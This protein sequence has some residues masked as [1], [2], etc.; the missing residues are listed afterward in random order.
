MT[1]ILYPVQNEVWKFKLVD[2]DKI[3]EGSTENEMYP[4]QGL[5]VAGEC[6]PPS[7]II[8]E[9][10]ITDFENQITVSIDEMGVDAVLEIYMEVMYP[11]STADHQTLMTYIKASYAPSYFE[12]FEIYLEDG[13]G[14]RRIFAVKNDDVGSFKARDTDIFT[15]TADFNP[16]Y[17]CRVGIII[18]KPKKAINTGFKFFMS[19]F[20]LSDLRNPSYCKPEDVIRFLGL[21]D[22][23]G[24]PL[25]LTQESSPSYEDVCNHI[26]EAE[27]FIDAQTRT[28]F[29][30]NRELNEMHDEKLAQSLPYG[31]LYGIYRSAGAPMMYG[32]QLFEGVP[33]SLF[34]Q[35]IRPIDYSLGDKVEV[36]RLGT[37]WET[38]PE[39]RLWWD[40]QKGIIYIK[41]YFHRSD[42]SVRVTYRW[43]QD[44]VPHDITKCC[45]IQA[46][47]QIVATDW[48]RA[49]FPI[50]PEFSDMKAETL[51]SWTWEIKD[52]IK[53]Y[54]TQ[55]SVGCL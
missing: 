41:D 21:L 35:N 24:R 19:E 52:I 42:S 14:D 23:R 48:Y 2:G 10:G 6:V 26:I 27:A 16:A 25:I 38:L 44:K 15:D 34:R 31:G 36:R 28:S 9:E 18:S 51:N 7:A 5:I 55:I 33:V 3:T 12:Q 17:I 40:A 37:I 8:H 30:I 53:G 32:G 50:A 46:S 20:S 13:Q 39:G 47:K 45:K 4:H 49:Q 1:D 29:K 54:Q 43:G 11:F 22:N